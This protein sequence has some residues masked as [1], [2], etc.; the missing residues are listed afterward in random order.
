MRR[1]I[2]LVVL[3]LAGGC[4]G[5]FESGES[6]TSV[7]PVPVDDPPAPG[8]P[9]ADANAAVQL[10]VETD[11]LLA[12]NRQ[13]RT[14]GSYTLSRS[15]VVEGPNSSLRLQHGQRVG[16]E[17][18]VI[19]R[20]AANG[21][22]QIAP[23]FVNG[24]L[25]QNGPTRWTRFRLPNG[26][27]VTNRMPSLDSSPFITGRPLA[28]RVIPGTDFSVESRQDGALLRSTGT[29]SIDR[30]VLPASMD[31]IQEASVTVRVRNDGL[32]RKIAVTY[33]AVVGGEEVSVRI[34][35]RVVETG[36][37]SLSRPAWVPGQ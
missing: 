21:S 4:V 8:V 13:V 26:D 37:A 15:V 32:V 10:R 22:G 18:A 35:Q 28:E 2:V 30:A 11:R 25:W 29:V 14:N 27:L 31:D 19:E 33:D 12:A 6:P 36:T 23:V 24:T 20:V 1:V 16:A 3:V 17:G 34:N 5:L 9:P 7:T